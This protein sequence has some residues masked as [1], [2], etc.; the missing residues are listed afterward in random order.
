M[1]ASSEQTPENNGMS[2]ELKHIRELISR[3]EAIRNWF[4]Y[5][6]TAYASIPSDVIHILD[7]PFPIPESNPN[8]EKYVAPGTISIIFWRGSGSDLATDVAAVLN[9]LETRRFREEFDRK[10]LK[11]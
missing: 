8:S 2:A 10:S 6:C 1:S 7:G 3:L 5:R 11:D 4:K 9:P